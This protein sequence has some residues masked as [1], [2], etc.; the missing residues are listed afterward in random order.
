MIFWALENVISLAWVRVLRG[1]L[2]KYYY[3]Y[4]TYFSKLVSK[5]QGTKFFCLELLL[6]ESGEILLRSRNDSL[7]RCIV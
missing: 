4:Y 1:L 6:V 7:L 2:S 5:V 3:K